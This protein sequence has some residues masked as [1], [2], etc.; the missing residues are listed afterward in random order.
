MATDY[1]TTALLASIRRRASI[2]TTSVTGGATSD[3][4]AYANEELQLSLMSDILPKQEEY[5]SKDS[6]TT[7]TSAT[8]YR[9][10]SRAVGGVLR[11]V[12]LVDSNGA[13]LGTLNRIEPERIADYPTSG[14]LAGFYIR[15]N[16]VVLVPSSSSTAATLRM[17]YFIRP[18]QLVSS[19]TQPITAINTS[20]KT[21]TV[22]TTSGFSTST[23]VDLVANTPGFESLAV[24]LTPS[25][26]GGTT[27]TFSS[28]LPTDL[29]VGDHL[30]LAGQ[31]PIPQVPEVY[32]PILAQRVAC[33]YLEAS[34]APELAAAAARL[35]KME[36]AAG[37]LISPRS[38]GNPRKLVNLK[39]SALGY[40]GRWRSLGRA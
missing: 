15:N 13:M 40:G 11:M 1:T 5:F 14:T 29:A 7:L 20:T 24:D 27:V 9:L 39:S 35:Q 6:D 19:G 33:A 30:C 8:V 10:P 3:L 36:E 32:H 16:A 25:A 23:P 34:G 28:T 38:P 12:S 17:T 2:P 22:S 37:I 4:L 26:V 21:V 18:N 31:S